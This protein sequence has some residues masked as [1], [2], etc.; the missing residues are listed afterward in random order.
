MS[1]LDTKKWKWFEVQDIFSGIQKGERLT[2]DDRIDG[3]TPLLT[4]TSEN[5]GVSTFIER[6]RYEN[7]KIFKD[8]ITV[9]MFFNVFYHD[10]EYFSDDNVHTMVPRVNINRYISLFLCTVLKQNQIKYAYGRQVRLGRLGKEK[11][12]LPAKGKDPDWGLMENY[13]E[14]IY[15]EVE[16][17]SAEDSLIDKRVELNKGSWQWFHLKDVFDISIAKSI[18]LLNVQGQSGVINYVGRTKENNGVVTKVKL[19]KDLTGFLNQGDCLS[20]VMVG[21]AGVS[22]YQERDFLS[23][24]NILLLRSESLNK[25]NALFVSNI[26]YLE[27]YRFSYGRTLS[28]SYFEN[29]K[30]K[31]PEKSG[32]PD[33]DFMEEYIKTLPYSASI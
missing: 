22:F 32:E 10:Y 25:Y 33:W 21:E 20:V 5:N 30:V 23:S 27:K 11:I 19:D 9:D 28:K 15:T 8:K 24:Q 18:D 16:K 12:K 26:I 2:Q 4:A 1:K 31:L 29:H 7:K 14:E 13:I 3:L 6:K 17:E